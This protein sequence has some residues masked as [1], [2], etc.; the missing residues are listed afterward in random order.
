MV[1]AIL[2][3]RKTKTRRIMKPQPPSKEFFLSKSGQDCGFFEDK[4]NQWRMSGAVGVARGEMGSAWPKDHAWR[5]PYGQPGDRLRMCEEITVTPV[6]A[7]RFGVLYHADQRYL[8]RYGDPG[9]MKR[10]NAYKT[11]HLRGVRLPDAFARPERPVI[12]RIRAER[13]QDITEED[14]IAEGIER[15]ERGWCD[16][17]GYAKFW[18][19]SVTSFESL[20]HSING[21][22]SWSA[23]PWVWVIEFEQVK[24]AA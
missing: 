16:Y 24:A 19:N 21:P 10:I 17:Q 2:D 6:A 23:N 7:D 1:R 4:T 15:A 13:L 9:L 5:C 12:T 20:W 11:G 18:M 22:E 8:E 3:G 14:A